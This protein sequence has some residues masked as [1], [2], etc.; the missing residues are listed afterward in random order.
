[1]AST[2]LLKVEVQSNLRYIKK[3]T[4][5][6]DGLFRAA[7]GGYMAPLDSNMLQAALPGIVKVQNSPLYYSELPRLLTGQPMAIPPVTPELL[8]QVAAAIMAVDAVSGQSK[9]LSDSVVFNNINPHQGTRSRLKSLD[10]T[11][12]K[13][14]VFVSDV[15]MQAI[16]QD[17]SG[18]MQALKNQQANA[19]SKEE[20]A[21]AGTVARRMERIGAALSI[22]T[23]TP[24][25]AQNLV[26][27]LSVLASADRKLDKIARKR[28]AA[29][30]D[31][32]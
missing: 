16:Y 28:K 6:A 30:S 12:K 29:E 24:E 8:D 13:M 23:S 20:T 1:M 18:A 11:K 27:L 25:G 15:T 19:A 17:P 26:S 14:D 9:A 22:D 4:L 31:S 3:V 7:Q 32:E 10:D 21:Y 2:P 5:I